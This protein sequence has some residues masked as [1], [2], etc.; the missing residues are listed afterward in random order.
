MAAVGSI[1]IFLVVL[2]AIA[3]PIA[4]YYLIRSEH[5]QRERMDR[6]TAERTAR[7]DRDDWK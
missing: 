3:F 6:E 2:L 1:A 4:L 5:D 7:R